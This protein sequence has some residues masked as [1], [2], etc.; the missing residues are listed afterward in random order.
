MNKGICYATGDII[1]ILNS[2]DIFASRN[3]VTLIAN[4]F[5]SDVDFVFGDLAYFRSKDCNKLVRH[6][7][8]RGFKKWMLKFGITVPH[9]SLYV[10]RELYLKYGCYKTNFRVAADFDFIARLFVTNTKFKRIPQILVKM[11]IGGI[12]TTGLFW[13]FHQNFE[14]IRACKENGIYT[15]IFYLIFKIPYKLSTYSNPFQINF[16]KN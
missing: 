1:G 10:R 11:R 14:I 9:P 4:S 5:S 16:R 8:S 3:I 6:Y 13:I 2:D 12:S 15:N 7:S